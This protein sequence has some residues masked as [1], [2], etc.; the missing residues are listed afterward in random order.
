MP[1]L[2]HHHP[3]GTPA[4]AESATAA[5]LE[6]VDVRLRG[7]APAEA[8]GTARAR[9]APLL[10]QVREPVPSV[11][12]ILTQGPRESA[13]RPAFAEVT[14]D[15]DGHPVRAHAEAATLGEAVDLL[16]DRLAIRLVRHAH[17]FEETRRHLPPPPR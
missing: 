10:R 16:R 15:V 11:R 13:V 9:I 2:P 3:A 5:E 12:V 8:A 4:P 14:V 6:I 17:R 7:D 1:R